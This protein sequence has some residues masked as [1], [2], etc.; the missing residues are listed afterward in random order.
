[1]F[2]RSPARRSM[3]RCGKE[4]ASLLGNAKL[5]GVVAQAL[6]ATVLAMPHAA[7]AQTERLGVP[8]IPIPL[9]GTSG[10]NQ[11]GLSVTPTAEVAYDD[12]IFRTSDD[13]AAPVDDIIVTPAL[14]ASYQRQLGQ[15]D[16]RVDGDL[17]YSFYTQNTD[18][19]RVRADIRGSGTIRIAGICQIQPDLRFTRQQADYGDINGPID[20]FQTFSTLAMKASCPRA[21]GF[22][23]LAEL[24]RRTTRNDTLFNFADQTL[25]SA[26]GGIGYARP[27]LGQ[28]ALFYRYSRADR[29]TIGV[30]N[31]IDE[32]GVTFNRAVVS[33]VEMSVD[34]HYLQASSKGANVR[35]YRGAGWDI[36]LVFRPIPRILFKGEAGRRIVNDSLVPAGFT[37]QTDYALSTEWRFAER[38]LLRG[39]AVLGR[40]QFR[41]DPLVIAAPFSSDRFSSLTLGLTR[42]MGERLNLTLDAQRTSRRTNTGLNNYDADRVAA[43]V[44]YRF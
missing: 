12:N 9:L 37:V 23:P 21:V 7:V 13:R 43:G 42:A 18:R 5:F 32:A 40:R 34:L 33:R 24:S 27:S 16:L 20:N 11:P 26:A 22:F 30:V 28:A 41:G 35:P 6:G 31:R 17:G 38:T 25:V 14:R 29:P 2:G 1:M 15:N 3:L 8:L 10:V 4:N 39:G 36:D 44:S 19:S